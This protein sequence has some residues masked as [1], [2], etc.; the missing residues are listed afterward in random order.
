[1]NKY[2][3][4][5]FEGCSSKLYAYIGCISVLEEKKILCNIK[6]FIGTSSGSIIALLLSLGYTPNEIKDLIF[7]I[8][9]DEYGAKTNFI[10][11]SYNLI[12]NYGYIK[13][14]KYINWIKNVIK[15]KTGNENCTFKELYEKTK[16][17][18]IVTGTCINKRETHYYNYNSNPNMELYRAV[19][20]SMSLP[21]AFPMIKWKDDF[22]SDGGL[23]ENFPIF[24]I[25][26]DN[27]LPNSR[28]EIVKFCKN[29]H[30]PNPKTLGVKIIQET[31]DICKIENLFD[32]TKE[33]Y[34]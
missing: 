7:N 18:L 1:M 4:I 28:K 13:P 2:E 15:A 31:N 16:N 24:Y 14:D 26:D 17:I 32:F 34:N 5:V 29:K 33:I 19:L 21:Y 10:I 12:R 20:I 11:G 30:K 27:N 3:N 6:R 9:P 8:N 25:Q 23:L 22:L